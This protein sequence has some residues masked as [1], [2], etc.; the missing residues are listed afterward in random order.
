VAALAR[1]T[2]ALLVLVVASAGCGSE[3]RPPPTQ[4]EIERV[5]ALVGEIVYECRSFESGFVAEPDRRTLERDADASFT[6]GEAPGPVRR[7]SVDGEL[8]VARRALEGC[9]PVMERRLREARG[10]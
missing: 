1:C 6:V 5:G 3:E 10:G 4:R 2:P 7:T 9:D 8:D